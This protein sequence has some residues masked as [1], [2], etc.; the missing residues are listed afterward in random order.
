MNNQNVYTGQ[1]KQVDLW[2]PEYPSISDMYTN[3]RYFRTEETN[4]TTN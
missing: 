3:N 1:T 4:Q 2:Q